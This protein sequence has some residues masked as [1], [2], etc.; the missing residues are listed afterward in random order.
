MLIAAAQFLILRGEWVVLRIRSAL[1]RKSAVNGGI[2]FLAPVRQGGGEK[3]L[4]AQYLADTSV[5]RGS[6]GL[7]Q[8]SLL[9]FSRERAP[10]CSGHYFWIDG[11]ANHCRRVLHFVH[12]S[13]PSRPPL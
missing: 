7:Y 5:A 4:A 1:G 10:S 12:D 8:N 2:A 11:F 6:L 13:F 9:V 3:P